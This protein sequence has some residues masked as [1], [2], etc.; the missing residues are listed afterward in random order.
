MNN[1]IKL[2]RKDSTIG[3]KKR[4][5][6]NQTTSSLL[7]F[8]NE[9]SR[10]SANKNK[11]EVKTNITKIHREDEEVH[12]ISWRWAELGNYFLIGA[13]L[14]IAAGVK[15]CYH[16]SH[17]L[18]THIPESWSVSYLFIESISISWS[19]LFFQC[20]HPF[21]YNCRDHFLVSRWSVQL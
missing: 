10:Q 12:L 16:H 11:S 13:F 21:R 1:E 8:V 18:S 9:T 14:L 2:P 19:S 15:I 7:G 17:T 20:S 4:I 6:N 3:I 5:F